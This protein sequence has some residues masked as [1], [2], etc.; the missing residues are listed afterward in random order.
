M[1]WLIVVGLATGFVL[2][3]T[4]ARANGGATPSEDAD[5]MEILRTRRLQQLPEVVDYGDGGL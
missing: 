1:I 2:L 3:L 5:Q 4:L